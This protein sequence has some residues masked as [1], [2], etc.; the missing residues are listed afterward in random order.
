MAVQVEERQ[1]FWDTP[2][3]ALLAVDWEKVVLIVL[4]VLAIGTRFWDLG[5]R[6]YNHDESIHTSWSHD[7]YVGKGYIHNP[8]YHGPLLY[9]LTAATFFL[10]GDNDV[11]GRVPN[12]VFGIVL[13]ALPF[14][15]R[16]WL[17]RRGWIITSLILLI[18]PVVTYYSRFN[19]HDIY[20]EVFVVLMLLVIMKY[21][22]SRRVEAEKDRSTYWLFA[23]AAVLGFSFTAMETTFIFI[24]LFAYF[25]TASFTLEWLRRKDPEG[26]PLFQSIVA[27]LIGIPFF[28]VH[29]A[30]LIGVR[31]ANLI[32]QSERRPEPWHESPA[33][34]L[35]V[36][37]GTLSLP[38]VLTPLFINFV[39][40]RDPLDYSSTNA[41][42]SSATILIASILLSAVFGLFWDWRKWIICALLFYPI[43]IFFFTTVFTNPG[44]LGTGFIGSLGYWLTQQP[45]QRGSQPPYYYLL[46]TLPMYEYLPYLFGLLGIGYILY[47]RGLRQL[48]YFLLFLLPLLAVVCYIWFTSG[49]LSFLSETI[50]KGKDTLQAGNTTVLLLGVLV[51]VFLILSHDNDN[52]RTRFPTLIGIWTLGVLI[53]FSWAGEK[54]PW[55]NMHLAIP[56]AFVAGYLMER[57][58][59]ADWRDLYHRGALLFG[60][61][62]AL[63]LLTL[64]FQI[65][66][67]PAPLNT[68]NQQIDQLSQR[69][70]AILSIF[71]VGVSVF[72]LFL[73]G[74]RLGTRDSLR[75]TL[76]TLFA[77]LA[78]L[79]IHS[80][81]LA[82]YQNSDVAVE[83]IIYAQGTPDVPNAMREIQEL[84]RRLCAQ[85][86]TDN[87]VKINCDNNTIKV[88]YDDDASWPFVW[89]LRNY[90]NAQFYGK[91]P[92]A[93]FDAEVVIV[94][95]ANE[96]AV[97]PFL[98]NKYVRRQMRLIWWPDENYKDLTWT[99]LFG[100]TDQSG[101][102]VKGILIGDNLKS[103]VRD[104]WFYHKYPTSLSSWPY[105]HVF[106]MYVRRDV[107]NLLWQYAGVVAPPPAST[108]E[109]LY[110]KNFISGVQA[111]STV[112][113]AGAGNGQ[114][115]APHNIALAAQGDLYVAD[116]NNHRVLKFDAN[117]NFVMQWGGQGNAP[118]QFNEPWG[119][120]VDKQR[121]VYVTDTWNH[122]VEK[123]DANGK[124]LLQWG[125][126]GDGVKEPLTAT[127]F[128]GPR[129]IA[130]DADGNLWI[131][132]TG[133]KRVLKF[134]PNG[135][136]LGEFGGAGADPGQY[137]EPVGIAVDANGNIFVADTWNQRIQ[138]FDK[139]FNPIQQWTVEA[140]DGQSVVNKP[141][142]AVDANG[143]VYAS[144]PEGYRIIKY[145]ND[146]KVL[147]V[148]GTRGNNLASFELP[149]GLAIAP[150]GRIY[151]ADAGNNRILIFAPIKQ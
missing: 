149:T 116:S 118:G 28:A 14:F 94:G 18:S 29:F 146:G 8:I 100:G 51:P 88:A 3:T 16:R 64:A 42:V 12:A 144:D 10:F 120:A 85:S 150:D 108:E 66:I 65:L 119:I 56:L 90:R 93:P 32:S 21:L 76:V 125:T 74:Q 57:V 133:N 121:N 131:T 87:K 72:I 41:V 55:L 151:V 137:L 36:V 33:Y 97:K 13:V 15:F 17:G 6:S 84:S 138:K 92:G 53:L 46:V 31:I 47:K 22:K 67:G 5:A 127:Q 77:A 122:R 68:G 23:A 134:D 91:S 110:T 35:S 139:D 59:N 44:G 99:R 19:R 26:H 49:I 50:L 147:A 52:P 73:I 103:L 83:T 43:T 75:V 107:A 112:G 34:D 113:T 124:F 25:L 27:A 78:L 105:V 70:S 9:H 63:A 7:L 123:F 45:V 128:Y 71:V 130:V 117:G 109:D 141:Y 81:A 136:S 30:Y 129:A 145:S 143:N 37:L 58:L 20:V 86:A 135:Q 115:N 48:G 148:W 69:A 114:F 104:V 11:T 61:L 126:F 95:S 24:A 142:L 82:A 98:G 106:S 101:N 62:L 60:L 89:Y 40:H 132:D 39:L 54:M 140:W 38:L 1:S 96:S 4:I 79:T 102:E 2:I 111:Q 80:T